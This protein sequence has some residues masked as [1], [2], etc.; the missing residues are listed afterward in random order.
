MGKDIVAAAF[1]I[2]ALLLCVFVVAAVAS[3]G[4]HVGSVV[5]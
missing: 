5:A 1:A 4:W 3:L 2:I